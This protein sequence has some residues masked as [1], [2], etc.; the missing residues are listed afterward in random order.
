[1]PTQQQQQRE[2]TQTRVPD[3]QA[4]A[5]GAHF[6]G[7]V[8]VGGGGAGALPLPLPL[9]PLPI[10]RQVV[11]FVNG[12]TAPMVGDRAL[13]RLLVAHGARG[14]IERGGR[15]GRFVGVEW[16]LE[17]VK[18][19]KRLSEARFSNLRIAAPGQGV[20]GFEKGEDGTGEN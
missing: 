18:A 6:S 17:S 11:V 8:A 1:M 3:A 13:K 12:S 19:G 2:Q 7:D 16:V 4:P 9:P 10:F 15:G 5:A 20:L 14:E